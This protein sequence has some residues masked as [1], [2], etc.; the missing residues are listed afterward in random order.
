VVRKTPAAAPAV[1]ASKK[2]IVLLYN[3]VM[4]SSEPAF[5]IIN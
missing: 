3:F 4:D 1:G 5:G 2:L